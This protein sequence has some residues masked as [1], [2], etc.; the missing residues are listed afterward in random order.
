MRL[1]LGLLFVIASAQCADA[2]RTSVPSS[3]GPRLRVSLSHLAERARIAPPNSASPT[4]LGISGISE[5]W[6]AYDQ[7]LEANPLIVK[8]VTASIILGAAD[9]AGQAFEKQQRDDDKDSEID[10]AR[11][12]RFAIFGLVLQ[13]PWNHFYYLLLDSKIPP[14]EE[15][16]SPTNA[17]KIVIDQGLQAPVFTVLIFVF[18]G[19]LEGKGRDEIQKQLKND[20][21]DTLVANCT[22]TMLRLLLCKYASV[23][24]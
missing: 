9:L 7:A 12:V 23:D 4:A 6:D 13:A 11:A 14:T 22:P 20:Y 8:S 2:F 19:L 17:M 1:V 5:A 10:W 24:S 15:P 21:P 18:L 3:V 16:F